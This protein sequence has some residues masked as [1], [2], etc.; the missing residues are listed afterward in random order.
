VAPGTTYQISA[1]PGSDI[2][3]ISL[4]R[5]CAGDGE[6]SYLALAAG[7]ASQADWRKLS[8]SFEAP[9][10]ELTQLAV[11]FEGPAAG[12]DFYLDDV[13]LAAMP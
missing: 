7:E 3:Q 4:R 9:T 10:C 5:Q 13:S 2:A 6:P 12:V 8:A 11:Y 1:G